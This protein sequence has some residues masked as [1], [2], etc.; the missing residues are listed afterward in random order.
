MRENDFVCEDLKEFEDAIDVCLVYNSTLY[1]DMLYKKKFVYRYKNGK[2]DLF[3]QLSQAIFS[4]AEE[5]KTLLLK[6]EAE[7]ES[8]LLEQKK[9]YNQVYGEEGTRRTYKAFF[10]MIRR[11]NER[12]FN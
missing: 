2:I 11:N 6:V 8:S 9:L 10:E 12:T 3:P 7:Y 4:T 5:L 1:T